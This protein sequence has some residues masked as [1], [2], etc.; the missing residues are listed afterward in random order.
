MGPH[1][2]VHGWRH[3]DRIVGGKK[4]GGRQIVRLAGRHLRH[5]VGGRRRN[6][7]QIA[8]AR[9]PYMADILLVLAVKKIGENLVG[10]Q[11]TDGERR[12]EFTRAR[13]QHRAHVRS[14]LAQ[15]ANEV[16]RLVGG[17]TARND[18][19]NT[20]AGETHETTASGLKLLGSI[21][22]IAPGK[23]TPGRQARSPCARTGQNRPC[24]A[25]D[26]QPCEAQAACTIS[27]SS[28]SKIRSWPASGWLASIVTSLSSKAT[29]V[30][31]IGP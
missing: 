13:R 20:L 25:T 6:Q 23:K 2:R 19:K 10:G 31:E 7:H 14:T 22:A 11:S 9:E 28:T 12:D 3:E 29:T 30:S 24:R 18:Q 16:E 26:S 8:V 4:N 15:T 5:Q 1:G 17:N 27:T 21:A